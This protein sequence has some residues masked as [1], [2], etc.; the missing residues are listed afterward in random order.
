MVSSQ[1]GLLAEVHDRGGGGGHCLSERS[2]PLPNYR[3]RF[4]GPVLLSLSFLL[5][6]PIFFSYRPPR[7]LTAPTC[8]RS[9]D[10]S[11]SHTQHVGICANTTYAKRGYKAEVSLTNNFLAWTSPETLYQ[12]D[13]ALSTKPV[14]HYQGTAYLCYKGACQSTQGVNY[15]HRLHCH[16]SAGIGAAQ[17]SIT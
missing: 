6:P 11:A 17:I 16:L 4:L 13:D 9:P 1:P 3:P 12:G 5:P 7:E 10:Q 8:W 15:G 2:Y 14:M